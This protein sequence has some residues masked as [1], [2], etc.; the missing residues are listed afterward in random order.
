LTAWH[1]G[2]FSPYAIV[3]SLLLF[4]LVVGVLVC[5]YLSLGLAWLAPN[6][7]DRLAEASAAVARLLG[8]VVTSLEHLPAL[9][10]DLYPIPPWLIAAWL[11]VTAALLFAFAAGKQRGLAATAA[12]AV[13]AGLVWTQL[14]AASPDTAQLH[15]LD[16]GS[17]QTTVLRTPS[18]PTVLFD[19]GGPAGSDTCRRV[20][21][22]FLLETRLPD[23]KAAFVSHGN[24][25]H[26]TALLDLLDRDPIETLYVSEH[27]ARG[28][29]DGGEAI[30]LRRLADTGGRLVRLTA[31][32]VVDLDDRTRVEVLWPPKE[33]PADLPRRENESSLV[34][35]IRCDDRSVLL[36]GDAEQFAI[37]SLL[38]RPDKPLP[39]CSAML[40]PHHGSWDP[41]LPR[42]VQA[43]EPEI[44]LISRG[45]PLA[46]AG[47]AGR[48]YRDLRAARRLLSTDS[49][50]YLRLEFGYGALR[51]TSWRRAGR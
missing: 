13:A 15:V 48:F 35:R 39:R 11:A 38:S 49:E 18:G 41:L 25:D 27:F 8:D 46:S 43:V 34:L 50:G 7:S 26:Y 12:A 23:P 31:G 9:S 29:G 10:V 32:D 4:P 30:L 17:G 21:R 5:G 45:R 47:P 2:I 1:F 3:L 42:I 36:P 22:P 19:A 51:V 6:L 40:L 33:I 37:Q 20:L 28:D 44:V 14:P 24:A 16:V